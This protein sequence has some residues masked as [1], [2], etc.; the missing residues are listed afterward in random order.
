MR[1]VQVFLCPAKRGEQVQPCYC[2]FL[3]GW[4]A[5][6]AAIF[7]T[8]QNMPVNSRRGK[9]AAS[10]AIN[11]NALLRVSSQTRLFPKKKS[12]SVRQG[13]PFPFFAK[14]VFMQKPI[15]L[16]H[17]NQIFTICQTLQQE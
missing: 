15:F 6:T 11:A 7:F 13:M 10:I 12:L 17:Y 14:I 4:P 9:Q 3:L 2:A 5:R 1:K 16:H 8:K